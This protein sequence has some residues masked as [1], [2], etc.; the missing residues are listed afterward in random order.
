LLT[1]GIFFSKHYQS[2]L[3]SLVFRKIKLRKTREHQLITA[4]CYGVTTKATG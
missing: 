4:F 1:A 3:C 2:A